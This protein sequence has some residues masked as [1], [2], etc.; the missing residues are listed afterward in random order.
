M[1][2]N[3]EDRWSRTPTVAE[4]PGSGPILFRMDGAAPGSGPDLANHPGVKSSDQAEHWY[5][6]RASAAYLSM[7]RA[8]PAWLLGLDVFI[9]GTLA[10]AGY[11]GTRVIALGAMFGVSLAM[12]VFGLRSHAAG[13]SPQGEI[14]K[15]VPRFFLNLLSQA[16]TGGIRSPLQPAELIPFS[17]LVIKT[18]WSRLAKANLAFVGGGLLALAVLPAHWFGPDV[19]QPAHWIIML[20]ILATAGAWHTRYALLLTRTI[21]DSACQLGRAR[22]EM[23]YRALEL[24]PIA[25]SAAK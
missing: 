12:L 7:A 23:V 5:R 10:L 25:V 11:P 14:L 15:M 1:L 16:L 6:A 3:L 9:V 2:H 21:G 22:E 8:K 19:P 13:T 17:D 24:R 20:A 18:G 4:D